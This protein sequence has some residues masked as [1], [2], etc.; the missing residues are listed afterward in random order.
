MDESGA[1]SYT[2]R[3]INCRI[4]AGPPFVTVEVVVD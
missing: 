3:G 2:E 1:S 4:E